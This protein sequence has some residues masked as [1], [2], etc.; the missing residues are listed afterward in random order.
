[1]ELLRT[2]HAKRAFLKD[3][4]IPI[5]KIR[6]ILGA[7]AEGSPSTKNTQPWGVSIVRGQLLE[8][9]RNLLLSKFDAG[10]LDNPEYSNRPSNPTVKEFDDKVAS[11][12]KELFAWKGIDRYNEA[13]RNEHERVNY[14]CFGA[15]TLLLLHIPNRAVPG[16]F[17]DAGLFLQSVL[18]GFHAYGYGACP[19]YSMAKFSKTLKEFH[20]DRNI[21]P[22]IPEDRILVCGISVGCIDP[23]AKIN[24]FSPSRV[25]ADA[26]IDD[27]S[28]DEE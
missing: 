22:L 14:E 15:S 16:T 19:Q 4:T 17:I 11:Y 10:E 2:R 20:K 9:L 1:M 24:S 6:T 12:G 21:K 23:D 13:Q 27:I 26:W 18:L 25:P 3:E 5:E 28:A 7:A 8:D